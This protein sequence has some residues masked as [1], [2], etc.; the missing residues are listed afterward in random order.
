MFHVTE[1]IDNIGSL[2]EKTSFSV[3]SQF[4]TNRISSNFQRL[5]K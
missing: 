2:L 4:S 3:F 5:F 1:Y